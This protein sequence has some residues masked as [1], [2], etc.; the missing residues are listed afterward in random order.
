MTGGSFTPSFIQQICTEPLLCVRDSDRCY[1]CHVQC[2]HRF[3]QAP[4]TGDLIFA[5]RSPAHRGTPFSYQ[6]KN[7]L[8]IFPVPPSIAHP[9]GNCPSL[10]VSHICCPRI[11]HFLRS[12]CW[13]YDDHHALPGLIGIFQEGRDPTS[14][15]L[16]A[17]PPGCHIT[18][19]HHI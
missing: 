8:L 3:I 19:A 4:Q 9:Q 6:P 17:G 10:P 16:S 1:K 13:S 14:V 11:L 7:I 15:L 5:A 12:T 18:P 2:F